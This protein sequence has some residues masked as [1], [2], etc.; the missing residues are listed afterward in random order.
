[1]PEPRWWQRMPP[2]HG[3]IAAT[4]LFT[5]V[6]APHLPSVDRRVAT[7]A[8]QAFPGLG[9]LLGLGAGLV[10]GA[11][12]LAGAGAWLAGVIAL[13]LLTLATGGF[14]LDGVADVADGLG[15][16][17]PTERALE[18]MKR[19]DI[20]P[21]GVISLMLVLLLGLGALTSLSGS[22][23][24]ADL[25]DVLRWAAVIALGPAVGRF[26]VVL[27]T[28]DRVPCARPGGFGALVAGVSSRTSVIVH[29]LLLA[30]LAAAVGWWLGGGRTLVAL[31]VAV[32]LAI[33]WASLWLRHL[34]R[35]LGG[36]TG[37]C[38]GS[39][40]ETTQLAYWLCAALAIPL[41]TGFAGG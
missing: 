37:D 12:L 27:A 35:R 28:T 32:G 30:A 31:V 20:G 9:L 17:T 29:G 8:V 2:L 3:L 39:L 25:V 38:F 13:A 41:T 1:M 14:H 36:V 22:L 33:A 18:I 16:R 40:I 15:S 4:S 21:M 5:A 11:V 10:S 7:L 23:P 6:P 19:S 34:L 24:V 26:A